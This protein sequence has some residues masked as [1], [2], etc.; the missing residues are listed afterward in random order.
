MPK[1][2]AVEI[3][4]YG[5]RVFET[6][7]EF[8]RELLDQ[9]TRAIDA[10]NKFTFLASAEHIWHEP[11]DVKDYLTRK[12]GRHTRVNLAARGSSSKGI[13]GAKD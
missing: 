5:G 9:V 13:H 2:N 8:D 7:E 12:E 6:Q 4:G 1:E 11:S 3:Y 10:L